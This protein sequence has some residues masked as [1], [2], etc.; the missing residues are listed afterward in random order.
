MRVFVFCPSVSKSQV[1]PVGRRVL[2]NF[3][4]FIIRPVLTPFFF[5]AERRGEMCL[6]LRDLFVRVNDCSDTAA[7]VYVS[8]L[9]QNILS[10]LYDRLI[11]R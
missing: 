3:T 10:T 1:L 4:Y 11:V 9:F 2:E 8:L 5:T 7:A 6:G